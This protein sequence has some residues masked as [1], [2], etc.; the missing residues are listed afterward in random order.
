MMI[1]KNCGAEV[2]ADVAVCPKCGATMVNGNG[3]S[4][5]QVLPKAPNSIKG[6]V[7]SLVGCCVPFV[8]FVCATIGLVLSLQGQKIVQR[9]PNA[10]SGTGFLIAGIILGILGIMGSLGFWMYVIL[11]GAIF[12]GVSAS[13]MPFVAL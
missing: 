9:N 1:C 8:G 7:W 2:A 5:P 3:T 13:V 6:F 10:Y 4:Q 12:G 11:A